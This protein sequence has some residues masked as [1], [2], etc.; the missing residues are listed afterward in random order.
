MSIA[1]RIDIKALFG[2][3]PAKAI[4]Y[5]DSKGLHV[6]W[7]WQDT[8]DEAHARSFTIAKMTQLDLLSDTRKAI[9]QAMADGTGFR[10]FEQTIAPVMQ[11]KGW[12]GQK[13]VI[14]PSGDAQ[15]VQLGSPR[16]L[17][18]IYHTNRRSAVMAAKYQRLCEA[19][20]THPYWQYLHHDSAHP[21]LNHLALHG[22]VYA[23]S[24]PFWSYAFP[25]NGFGCKC[26]VKALTAKQ[27]E[28]LGISV[29]DIQSFTQNIG[30][31]KSSGEVYQATRYVTS[32]PMTDS[33]AVTLAAKSSVSPT[34]IKNTIGG[35]DAGFN[36]SPAAS[37]LMDQ[38]WLD[39]AKAALGDRAALDA[40]AK[41]MAS[42]ARVRG[43]IAWMRTTAGMGYSQNRTYG[44]G[45][46]S[47]KAMRQFAK[48]L[49]ESRIGSPVVA[50]QDHL[51]AGKK[52][53]RHA[54]AGDALDT[55]AYERIVRDFS[56]PD[57]E[58]WD[59]QN[60]H[61]LHIFDKGNGKVVKLSIGMGQSGAQVVSAFEV[62]TNTITEAIAGRVFIHLQ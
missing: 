1:D 11:A 17:T 46:L 49:P 18:T 15:L 3:A 51:I 44:V 38:L 45:L 61:V 47:D 60:K 20:E 34:K 27:A 32:R 39:K 33:Q 62:G 10:G 36:S 13:T 12:W 21:R 9:M 7:N 4:E 22:A 19:I 56:K 59:T 50:Y 23:A 43:F 41:D 40:V 26:T 8:L 55:A 48:H 28:M 37:H 58:L 52:A 2:L 16:R 57:Y 5:L 31:D 29:A 54:V 14:N 6:G 53:R 35:A 42:E 24:D 30:L 25:P